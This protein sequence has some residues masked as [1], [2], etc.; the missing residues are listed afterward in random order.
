MDDTNLW[1]GL[2]E[3]LD[4]LEVE[5]K[6]QDGVNTWGRSLIATGGVLNPPKCNFTIHDMVVDDQGR[7][8]YADAE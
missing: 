5:A 1:F 7:W 3:D 6:A 2:E 8:T 4:I